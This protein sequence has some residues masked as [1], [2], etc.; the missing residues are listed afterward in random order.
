MRRTPLSRVKSPQQADR[1]R[2]GQPSPAALLRKSWRNTG[3]TRDVLDA[4]YE[5]AGYSCEACGQGVGDRRGVDHSVHHRVPRG[6]GGTRWAG[7]NALTNLLLLCG[8]A[9]TGCHGSVESHRAAAV[10][11]GWLVLS[12]SDPATV[13]V[14]IEHGSRFVYLTADGQYSN[15]PPEPG[16]LVAVG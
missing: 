10:A 16:E 1:M 13:P 9:T 5:R 6:M 3:P 12:R 14:L 8:S 4:L 7:A 2:G 15:D 11:A